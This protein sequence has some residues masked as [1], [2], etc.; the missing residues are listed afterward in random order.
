MGEASA[1]ARHTGIDPAGLFAVWRSRRYTSTV[2]RPFWT[3][4]GFIILSACV[5]YYYPDMTACRSFRQVS[6]LRYVF[7]GFQN[8]VLEAYIPINESTGVW[9]I[10]ISI[11]LNVRM[12]FT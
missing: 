3:A 11:I 1:F 10:E 8:H 6:I 5:S 9:I 2:P 7:I 12:D 4:R